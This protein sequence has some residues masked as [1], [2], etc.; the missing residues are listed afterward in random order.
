MLHI[1]ALTVQVPTPT[2]SKEKC[3][4]TEMRTTLRFNGVDMLLNGSPLSSFS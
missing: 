2:L 3:S 1:D 4:V